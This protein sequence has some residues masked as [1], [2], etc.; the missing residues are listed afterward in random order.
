MIC[1]QISNTDQ[2]IIFHC[3]IIR[4]TELRRH[5]PE[6]SVVRSSFPSNYV[7]VLMRSVK[8]LKSKNFLVL[9]T[10]RLQCTVTSTVLTRIRIRV[11]FAPTVSHA[12]AS[13]AKLITYARYPKSRP[14]FENVPKVFVSPSVTK[15]RIKTFKMH[16]VRYLI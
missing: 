4:H 6:T 15:R 10:L 9:K 3:D 5:L 1:I 11:K 7:N 2:P 16:L 8:N 13:L 14:C 12:P